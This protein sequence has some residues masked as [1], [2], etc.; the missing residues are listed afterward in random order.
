MKGTKR[1]NSIKYDNPVD[2]AEE[3]TVN[4]AAETT[5]KTIK[6]SYFEKLAR[7]NETSAEKIMPEDKEHLTKNKIRLNEELMRRWI[8]VEKKENNNEST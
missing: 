4:D 8:K 5:K 1:L 2:E 3:E 7:K 6:E